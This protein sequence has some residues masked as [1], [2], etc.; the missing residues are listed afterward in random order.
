MPR[1]KSNEPKIGALKKELRE[2]RLKECPPITKMKKEQVKNELV[3]LRGEKHMERTS[4]PEETISKLK[5][6][7]AE[8]KGRNV[9]RKE[10]AEK[11]VEAVSTL[12]KKVRGRK[13]ASKAME[14]LKKV[15]PETKLEKERK[16]V[17]DTFQKGML[18]HN[19]KKKE[20]EEKMTKIEKLSKKA[21]KI[22]K[23]IYDVFPEASKEGLLKSLKKM[24]INMSIDDF[25][26]TEGFGMILK[27]RDG[28]RKASV[29]SEETLTPAQ[30]K[31]DKLYK[32][33]GKDDDDE[34]V[35]SAS[36]VEEK[37]KGA[38]RRK[39]YIPK[40]IEPAPAPV[41]EKAKRGRKPKAVEAPKVEV[42]V[43]EK[44]KRFAKGSAEA[45]AY[46]ASLRAK[47]GK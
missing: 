6:V 45:K 2:L 12:Q 41:K 27:Q 9:A 16:E 29:I 5:A 39:N 3:R 4:L 46:M 13:S 33:L 40:R 23:D 7:E 32:K 47:K 44:K 22:R 24:N 28:I 10:E 21:L 8:T 43:E 26:K 18:E 36:D 42:S 25:L 19:K 34:S 30:V 17:S 1:K 38:K 15:E 20:D 14:G 11:V 37:P 35:A 31:E